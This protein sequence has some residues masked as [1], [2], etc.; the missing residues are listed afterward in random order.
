MFISRK[1]RFNLKNRACRDDLALVLNKLASVL[2]G[3]GK[4]ARFLTLKRFSHALGLGNGLDHM[5]ATED[6]DHLFV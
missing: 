5:Q 3:Q 1:C 2:E 6:I 4:L